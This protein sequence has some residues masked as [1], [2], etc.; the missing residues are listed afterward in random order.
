MPSDLQ[1]DLYSLVLILTAMQG[2]I[3]AILLFFKRHQRR[4]INI[5]LSIILLA[6]S[7]EV[8]HQFLIESNV[9]YHIPMLVGFVLPFDSLVGIALFWYVRCATHPEK[10]NSAKQFIKHYAIFFSCV[11]LS[12][13]FWLMDFQPKLELMQTGVIDLHWSDWV[14][15]TVGLQVPI[16][17]ISFSAYLFLSIKMLLE[18]KARI[19]DIFSYRE[20]VT[21]SW[22]TN[23]LWLF[24]V[25]LFQGVSILIFFQD[26]EEVTAFMGFMGLFSAI[27]IFYLGI[28]GLMQPRIYKRSERSYMRK[29]RELDEQESHALTDKSG[30]STPSTSQHKYKKSALTQKDMERISGKIDRLLEQESIYLEPDLTMPQLAE[31]LSISPNYLSQT[32]NIHYKMSFFDFINSHRI[33]F[34]KE[35]LKDPHHSNKSV[36]DIA[37]EAAFNSRSAFYSAFKKQVNMTPNQF[38]NK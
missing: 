11:V 19:R 32:L 17:I 14:F 26:S 5:H 28:M 9:I 27:A 20:K 25:G 4:S 10:D 34:A 13:P 23:L 12:L 7:L 33:N 15:Y 31:K 3:F 29:V 21:L 22:L 1:F 35:I 36:I 24:L 2:F 16:K 30:L 38:R 6:I 8:L 18:H 37:V